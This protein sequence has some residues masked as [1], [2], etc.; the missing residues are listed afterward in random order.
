MGLFAGF[1]VGIEIGIG[2]EL[3]I[4]EEENDG[5][6]GFGGLGFKEVL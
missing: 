6:L 1:G 3:V 5:G 2:G 4:E